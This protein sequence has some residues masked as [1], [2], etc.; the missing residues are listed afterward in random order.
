M[1]GKKFTVNNATAELLVTAVYIR[2]ARTWIVEY[3]TCIKTEKVG[4]AGTSNSVA[5]LQGSKRDPVFQVSTYLYSILDKT[6]TGVEMAQPLSG[7]PAMQVDPWGLFDLVISFEGSVPLYGFAEITRYNHIRTF[8]QKLYIYHQRWNRTMRYQLPVMLMVQ[9]LSPSPPGK[10][11][12][13]ILRLMCWWD[14]THS[15]SS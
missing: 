3:I 13:G 5:Q 2:K 15:Y 11:A 4:G 10:L 1:S 12:K 14:H 9:H 6:G 7:L 8:L